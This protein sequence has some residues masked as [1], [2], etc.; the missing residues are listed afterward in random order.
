MTFPV[1]SSDILNFKILP[2]LLQPRV[3]LDAQFKDFPGL[4]NFSARFCGIEQIEQNVLFG[5]VD[6]YRFDKQGVGVFEALLVVGDHA[7]SGKRFGAGAFI[8]V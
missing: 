1:W 8:I 5:R 3:F 6:F 4:I 2:Y 7:E